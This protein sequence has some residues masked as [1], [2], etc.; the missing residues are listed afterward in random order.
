MKSRVTVQNESQRL[1]LPLIVVPGQGPSLL[2]RNWLVKL[3]LDWENIFALQA[4]SL[5][6]VLDGFTSF[7]QES[8]GILKQNKVKLF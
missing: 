1:T 2:G 3:Q 4:N 6:D 5:Q 8:L 7:F